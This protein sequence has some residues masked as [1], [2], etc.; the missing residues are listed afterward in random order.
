MKETACRSMAAFNKIP[1]RKQVECQFCCRLVMQVRTWKGK[2]SPL[3][4]WDELFL[5]SNRKEQ[6]GLCHGNV[7]GK[8]YQANVVKKDKL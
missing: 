8:D 7:R 3:G 2:F 6:G 5:Y 1:S 4:C